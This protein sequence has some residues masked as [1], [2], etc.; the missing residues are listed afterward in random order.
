MLQ[1]KNQDLDIF[2]KGHF[3]PMDRTFMTESFIAMKPLMDIQ[4]KYNKMD[5]DTLF[6]EMFRYSLLCRKIKA[7]DE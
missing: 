4:K 5:N 1:F 3:E 6:N 2:R 7:F